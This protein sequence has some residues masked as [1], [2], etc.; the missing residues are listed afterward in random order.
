MSYKH[1]FF[2][3][4]KWNLSFSVNDSI[5]AESNMKKRKGKVKLYK[6]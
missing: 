5:F 1:F 3:E 4:N 6:P 2:I